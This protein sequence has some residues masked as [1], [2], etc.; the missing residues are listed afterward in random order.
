MNV[1]VSVS[2]NLLSAVQQGKPN[3]SFFPELPREAALVNAPEARPIRWELTVENEST[4]QGVK[5]SLVAEYDN[6]GVVSVKEGRIPV[7]W[8]R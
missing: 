4:M 7:R 6:S 5:I 1:S 2:G 8:H 3:A